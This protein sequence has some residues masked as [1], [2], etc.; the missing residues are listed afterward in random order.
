MAVGGGRLARRRLTGCARIALQYRPRE[1][2][3]P[4]SPGSVS[5]EQEEVVM[6]RIL[7]PVLL[8]HLAGCNQLGEHY[9]KLSAEHLPTLIIEAGTEMRAGEHQFVTWG[10]AE[11]SSNDKATTVLFGKAPGAGERTCIAIKADAKSVVVHMASSGGNV[12]T[13]QWEV[14]R[15]GKYGE[16]LSLVRP[17]GTPVQLRRKS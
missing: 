6:S 17:D 15:G 13:E 3:I 16:R 4:G 1:T 12:L 14:R 8:I 10:D 2:V 11:C 9:Q 7:L 5:S